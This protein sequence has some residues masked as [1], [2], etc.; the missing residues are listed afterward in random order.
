MP[1]AI[2]NPSPSCDL[3]PCSVHRCASASSIP[4]PP[5]VQATKRR[6]LYQLQVNGAVS[7]WPYNCA[8]ACPDIAPG[9]DYTCAQQVRP[10][11]C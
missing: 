3:K 10:F 2:I 6:L 7:P 9:T 4:S 8:A 1:T 5:F 11:A